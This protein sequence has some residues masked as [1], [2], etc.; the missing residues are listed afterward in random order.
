MRGAS[1]P[2]F[3]SEQS[4]FG[5]RVVSLVPNSEVKI[6]YRFCREANEKVAVL[7]NTGRNKSM[8]QSLAISAG[9]KWAQTSDDMEGNGCSFGEGFYIKVKVKCRVK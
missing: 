4:S 7:T 2:L 3:N 6:L 1:V 5:S 9:Q 8:K